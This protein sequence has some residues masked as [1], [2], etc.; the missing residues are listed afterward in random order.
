MLILI[1]NAHSGSVPN[2]IG[3]ATI[4]R[5]LKSHSMVRNKF[6]T[7]GH[8]TVIQHFARLTIRHKFL[9]AIRMLFIPANKFIAG[10]WLRTLKRYRSFIRLLYRQF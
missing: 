2:F 6:C 10:I 8:R 5:R 4:R 3:H 7:N 1:F 9:N